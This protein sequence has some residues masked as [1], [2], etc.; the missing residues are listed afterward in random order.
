MSN[1]K[2]S[3]SNQKGSSKG[4]TS[5]HFGYVTAVDEATGRARVK[6]EALGIETFWL[7][8]LQ[9]RVKEDQAADWL[10]VDDF[11]AV[12][13]DEKLEQGVILGALY[14]EKNP[15]PIDTKDKWY[16]RFSDGSV[17]EFDRTTGILKLEVTKVEITCTEESTIN[18]KGIV[19]IGGMDNDTESNGPDAMVTTGQL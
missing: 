15:P 6:I 18:G 19:V 3:N 17:I 1:S 10:D 14:S 9:S 12:L 2:D 4:Q 8:I 11:V 16:R 7:A 5:L 13:G